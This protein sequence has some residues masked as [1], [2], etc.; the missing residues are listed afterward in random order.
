L[1]YRSCFDLS[2]GARVS[3]SSDHD[4][5][6]VAEAAELLEMPVPAVSRLIGRGL[7]DPSSRERVLACRESLVQTRREALAT[8]AAI[9]EQYGF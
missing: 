9:S 7:L 1:A 2:D 5:L 6:T 4:A 8:L 3:P